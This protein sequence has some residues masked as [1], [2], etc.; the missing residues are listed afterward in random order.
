MAASLVAVAALACL[1]LLGV[2][3]LAAVRLRAAYGL[4]CACEPASAYSYRHEEEDAQCQHRQTGCSVS[5][6]RPCS[7]CLNTQGTPA[8]RCCNSTTSGVCLASSPWASPKA[9]STAGGLGW[10][11]APSCAPCLLQY[12]SVLHGGGGGEQYAGPGH[13]LRD[14]PRRDTTRAATGQPFIR[15]LTKALAPVLVFVHTLVKASK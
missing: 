2:A 10:T 4:A 7:S 9:T 11:P 6:S 13:I 14:G 8:L 12:T 15:Q 5:S 3:L 1:L